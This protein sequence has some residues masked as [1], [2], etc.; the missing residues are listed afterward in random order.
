MA[1]P[2][3]RYNRPSRRLWY[4]LIAVNVFG[5]LIAARLYA[6]P[7]H[8]WHDP[9]SALGGARTLNGVK[10]TAGMVAFMVTMAVSGVTLIRLSV[11]ERDRSTVESAGELRS[12]WV[13][14]EVPLFLRTLLTV[15][16][17]GYWIAAV[18]YDVVHFLHSLGSGLAVA[19]L[20]GWSIH[21]LVEMRRELPHSVVTLLHGALHWSVPA[22]AILFAAGEPAKQGV[23][24]LAFLMLLFVL[25]TAV[26][27]ERR[28]RANRRAAPEIAT[29]R[30]G[31]N[32]PDSVAELEGVDYS[33]ISED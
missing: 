16:G 29:L 14:L 6:E 26:V 2:I 19:C 20:Y 21:F 24:K 11:T 4:T 31:R 28:D 18:P 12:G 17:V 32:T 27:V 15:G 7:F 23:Q 1:Q 8:F 30:S 9:F 25:L 5:T 22:Y 10:N 13:H 3:Q 33:D